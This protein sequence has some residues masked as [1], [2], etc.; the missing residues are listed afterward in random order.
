MAVD[1]SKLIYSSQWGKVETF[2]GEQF[3]ITAV[4]ANTNTVI[5][6]YTGSVPVFVAQFRPTSSSR[7][8][9]PGMNI[10]S[11]NLFFNVK[12]WALSGNIYMNSEM[13]GTARLSVM[14]DTL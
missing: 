5:G 3:K 12:V 6:T 11:S 2:S 10:N 4:S 7:W 1:D 13:A 14:E 8:Y 9:L